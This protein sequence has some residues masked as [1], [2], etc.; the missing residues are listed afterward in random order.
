MGLPEHLE[1]HVVVDDD[2]GILLEL[3]DK[4]HTPGTWLK[5]CA[6]PEKVIPLLHENWQVQAPEYLMAVALQG[7]VAGPHDGY[8]LSLST[9]GA[10][11]EAELRDVDGQLAA[12]GRVAHSD[13][14][15][16]FDQIVTELL[17]QRKGLGRVI[18]ATLVNASI[19][20][21]ASVGVLV[22]TE[23]GRALYQAIGWAMVSP[24]TAAVIA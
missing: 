24:V 15:A 11:T 23:Q 5:V 18:M 9:T 19:A 8:L 16:T 17:H 6:H 22:A 2:E 12:R 1:R 4:L 3:I 7:A 13:G 10:V 20:Q 21:E 14:V